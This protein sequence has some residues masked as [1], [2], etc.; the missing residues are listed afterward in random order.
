VPG[1]TFPQV[2]IRK[3]IETAPSINRIYE[4]GESL[5][6]LKGKYHLIMKENFSTPSLRGLYI[7]YETLVNDLPFPRPKRVL[8]EDYTFM[9]NG[10]G[11][12]FSFCDD[13]DNWNNTEPIFKYMINSLK[14]PISS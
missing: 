13:T 11:F 3:N 2:I 9:E 10:T 1:R 14:I 4:W 5:A 8:C 7:H 12:N 6:E